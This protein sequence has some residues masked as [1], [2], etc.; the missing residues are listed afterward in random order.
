MMRRHPAIARRARRAL[1]SVAACAAA[2]LPAIALGAQQPADTSRLL[3]APATAP[4]AWNDS[5]ALALV[6]R[7]TARRQAQ[8]AD[9]ALRDYRA[10][11]RGSLTFLGQVGEGFTEPPRVIQATQVATEV[12]WRAPDQSKQVV[13]GQ[14]DTTLLPTDNDFYRDRYGIVQNNFPSVIRLG[15]ATDVADV[16]HPLSAS[17]APAYDFAVR[18]SLT[19]RLGPRTV[20]V[21]EV[22]VRPRDPARPR[23]VG[24]LFL[25]PDDAQV[26]RMAFTFT[27]AAYLDQRN[28]DVSIVL[29]NALIQERFWLPRR[30]EVEVRRTGT[31]LD[32]PARGI[33]RGRWDIGD[34]QVNRGLTAA[35]FR[36]PELVFAPERERRAYRFAEPTVLAGLPPGVAMATDEDVRRV[37]AQAQELVQAR[38]LR[39]ARGGSLSARAVS[40]FVRVNRV[41]GLAVGAGIARDVGNGLRLSAGGRVGLDDEQVKGQAAAEQRWRGGDAVRVAVYRAYRDAG[42]APEVSLARNSLAAQEFGSDWTDPYDARGVS[43][44][45]QPRAWLGL[46]PALELAYEWQGALAVNARPV[47]GSFEATIPASTLRALRLTLAVERPTSAGPFATEWR[48]GAQ[49]RAQRT[50]LGCAP[51]DPDARWGPPSLCALGGRAQLALQVERPLGAGARSRLVS[52]SLLVAV[53]AARGVPAQELAYLGGPVTGPGYDFHSLAGRFGASQRLEWRAP[54]P[55]PAISLGRYGRSPASAT[56]APYGHAAWIG[57]AAAPRPGEPARGGWFPSVGL[58]AHLF[59][60]LVRVD[61]ARGL[62]DGRWLFS[63]DVARDF[64]RVL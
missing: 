27:R 53:D 44:A 3:T 52:H 56:L 46:R 50:N 35:Q 58:G 13:V 11:A 40:D 30:Q 26:V 45:W 38:T 54:V 14:R 60:D 5:A 36:G 42:D 32:F 39:R 8:L 33:I 9:T 29:E 61:V 47:N 23:L 49:L 24:S 18:D 43:V 20:R 63:V 59:F 2:A 21:L 64:W 37:Q 51:G 34:Y 12:Y 17:G 6:R 57:A 22:Q 10:L 31:F 1:R 7:A 16:P 15:N 19:I 28:E 25:D 55:F 48:A 62:R 4:G 41:E